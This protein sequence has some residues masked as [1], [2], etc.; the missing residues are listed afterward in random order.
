MN[1]EMGR[2]E[3]LHISMVKDD[4][5]FVVK[6]HCMHCGEETEFLAQRQYYYGIRRTCLTCG[7]FIGEDDYP[8]NPTAKNSR[9]IREWD[10]RRAAAREI[11]AAEGLISRA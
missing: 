2:S 1:D 10:A 8:T 6:I 9:Q 11:V 4:E 3:V 5:R 7:W